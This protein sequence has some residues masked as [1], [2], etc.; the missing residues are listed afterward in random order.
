MVKVEADSSLIRALID[1]DSAGR[2]TI[3]QL[4]EYQAGDRLKPPK[5]DIDENNV[6]TATAEIDSMKIYLHLKDRF[7]KQATTLHEATTE[8]TE[9]EVYR[10]PWWQQLWI[11]LGKTLSAALIGFILFELCKPKILTLWKK[12]IQ[13]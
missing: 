2:A 13:N 11:K 4:L 8:T 5:I 6:L 9:I 10:P 3:R 1:C 12:I 7:E